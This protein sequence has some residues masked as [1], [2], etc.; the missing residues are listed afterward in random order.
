MGLFDS[1]TLSEWR[2]VLVALRRGSPVVLDVPEDVR[3]QL[4]QRYVDVSQRNAGLA[5]LSFGLVL[6]VVAGDAPW[7]PRVLAFVAMSLVALARYVVV[8]RWRVS[9][10]AQSPRWD[11]RH[12]LLVLVAML[13]WNL[14]PFALEG[15]IPAPHLAVVVY[16]SQLSLTVLAVSHVAALP[17]SL[18][19]S[20]FSMV[21]LVAFFLHQ[22]TF[23]SAMMALATVTLTFALQ[24]RMRD[25]H[26]TLLKALAADRQNAL[27]VKELEGFRQRLEAENEL[28][29]LSLR[30]ASQAASRDP[31]TGLFNR[32][33]LLA[34]APAVAELVASQRTKVVLCMIDI[35]HFK[36]INDRH[37]HA[38]GDTV[39]RTLAKVMTERLREGDCVARLGGEE[40]V[41]MLRGCDLHAGRC[42]AD[43][44]REA[45]AAAVIGTAA[46]DLRISV[47]IG[48]AQWTP[49]E[50]LPDVMN[51]ADLALYR[52]KRQGR[53]RVD[54][55]ET[56]LSDSLSAAAP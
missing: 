13:L 42:V 10:Q 5:L 17:A 23:M 18:L 53:N 15:R 44:L 25:N 46:G 8:R 48:V 24:S 39:L 1:T 21:A 27:L 35:D 40:F 49:G 4:L 6:F 7:W 56:A 50:G 26:R 19:A 34:Q 2:S 30:D 45:I 52:A 54:V 38:V 51:R 43:M 32:R 41:A 3:N 37:G 20:G 22:G 12:D 16:A 11:G 29:G 9:V 47:S 28:L 55:D 33:H 31:L 14:A 36:S